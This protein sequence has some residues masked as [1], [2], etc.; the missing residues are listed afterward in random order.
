MLF[1]KG[2]PGPLV[3]LLDFGEE[4]T[5]HTWREQLLC[6]GSASAFQEAPTGSQSSHP[7]H[8]R[9]HARQRVWG[10]S[11]SSPCN[12]DRRLLLGAHGNAALQVVELAKVLAQRAA[13]LE[14]PGHIDGTLEGRKEEGKATMGTGAVGQ[15]QEPAGFVVRRI[16]WGRSL[17]GGD[18]QSWAFA[19]CPGR[20]E[21]GFM[22]KTCKT[23]LEKQVCSPKSEAGWSCF[24]DPE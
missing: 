3:P 8:P 11:S 15:E 18:G 5:R 10:S 20:K 17:C 4:H 21:L 9:P 13:A 1:P 16:G 19:G 7:Q 12:G 24:M 14:V 22:K 23:H 6:F 2:S